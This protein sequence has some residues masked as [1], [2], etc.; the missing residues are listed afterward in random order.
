MAGF[1]RSSRGIRRIA[2][3]S[4]EGARKRLGERLKH[5]ALKM[6]R[7]RLTYAGLGF[8]TG[9]EIAWLAG[10]LWLTSVWW[11]SS[12]SVAAGDAQNCS[13]EDARS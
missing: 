11:D 13:G 9:I 2:R 10:T 1:R 7:E 12:P 4:V 6:D 3:R 5:S 8:V